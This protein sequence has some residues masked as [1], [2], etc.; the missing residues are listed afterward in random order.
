MVSRTK[1]GDPSS[2]EEATRW[3]SLDDL[4]EVLGELPTPLR[5]K[6]MDRVE[7]NASTGFIA[8]VK[9]E[10]ADLLLEEVARRVFGFSLA[11][12]TSP[13]LREIEFIRK[14]LGLPGE[15]NPST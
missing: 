8:G 2:G 9:P 3:I 4:K 12:L 7:G 11:D 14:E 10:V 15:F 13:E 1:E 5:T 6:V